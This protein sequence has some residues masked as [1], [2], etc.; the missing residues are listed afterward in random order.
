MRLSGPNDNNYGGG[1]V[2]GAGSS[3]LSPEKSGEN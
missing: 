3:L 2:R 1:V